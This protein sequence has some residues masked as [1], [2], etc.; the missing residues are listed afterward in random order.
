[1]FYTYTAES[2]SDKNIDFNIILCLKKWW[3][4]PGKLG[5][6]L[7]IFFCQGPK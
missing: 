7:L 2:V 3:Q 4:R 1:M 5:F 6:F